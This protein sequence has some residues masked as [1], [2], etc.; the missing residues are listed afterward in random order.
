MM[1]ARGDFE[2]TQ[3][4]NLLALHINM[5]RKKGSAMI[6]PKKLNPFARKKEMTESK[7]KKI[8]LNAKESAEL[9]RNVF[10]K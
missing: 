10:C 2:W 4:A 6:D 5:N 9:L 1:E 8:K 3:T 7:E